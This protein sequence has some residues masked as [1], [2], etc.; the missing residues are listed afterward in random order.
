MIMVAVY[1]SFFFLNR[2]SMYGKPPPLPPPIPNEPPSSF[3]PPLPPCQPPPPQS[4]SIPSNSVPPPMMQMRPPF[5]PVSS[6]VGPNYQTLQYPIPYNSQQLHYHSNHSRTFNQPRPS[7]PSFAPPRPRY[8]SPIRPLMPP[9]FD[10]SS[11]QFNQD[12]WPLSQFDQSNQP[13]SQCNQNNQPL[14]QFNQSNQP[15]R[16]NHN[17][18]SP[19]W[20]GHNKQSTHTLQP[21]HHK[22]FD[23]N[24]QSSQL[25]SVET[26]RLPFNQLPSGHFYVLSFVGLQQIP[27]LSLWMLN[28]RIFQIIIL[29]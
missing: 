5:P 10:Q 21:D 28:E 1:L 16:F 13:P 25:H 9:Q 11:L 7:Q 27:F 18:Q 12:N 26:R 6:F 20:F 22:Q 8:N 29:N 23:R 19:S 2:Y 3:H 17:N 24:Q 15:P 4:E 14:S